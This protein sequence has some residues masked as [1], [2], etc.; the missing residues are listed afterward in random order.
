MVNNSDNSSSNININ[1]VKVVNEGGK[2]FSKAQGTINGH[3]VT[4]VFDRTIYGLT[5]SKVENLLRESTV[6]YTK[7]QKNAD[8]QGKTSKTFVKSTSGDQIEIQHGKNLKHVFAKL[9]KTNE[10]EQKL[11][12]I[13]KP[14]T[15]LDRVNNALQY[16]SQLFRKRNEN[17]PP[18]VEAST[19]LS[20]A[21]D[22]D[23]VVNPLFAGAEAPSPA[24]TVR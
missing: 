9:Q 17:S 20:L 2:A 6:N 23:Q 21:I 1:Q 18:P 16:V 14:P 7:E 22:E 19:E 4:V 5:P 24:E 12:S 3:S 15:L 10:G 8:G 11:A 13:Q